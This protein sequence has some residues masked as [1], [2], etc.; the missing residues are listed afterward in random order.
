MSLEVGVTDLTLK[1]VADR[2]DTFLVDLPLFLHT[3]QGWTP[4]D[5]WDLT[6]DEYDAIKTFLDKLMPEETHGTR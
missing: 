5:F 3:F 6:L 2:R 4:S 1:Q